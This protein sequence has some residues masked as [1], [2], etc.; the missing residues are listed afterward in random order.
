M[1][2]TEEWLKETLAKNPYLKVQVQGGKGEKA[3]QS[4]ENEERKQK[5][6]NHKIYEYEDG[7]VSDEKIISG[8]GAVA[9]IYDSTKEYCR[10]LDLQLMEKVGTITD[11]E[12]QK[13]L[14]IQDAFVYEK[15]H[16]QKIV[17]KADFCYKDADGKTIVCCSL[18][19]KKM[20]GCRQWHLLPM[21]SKLLKR[22]WS[23]AAPVRFLALSKAVKMSTWK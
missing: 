17:Y 4:K 9:A 11:L 21:V 7:F 18:K 23:F 12:R 5:Y 13:D 8:H 6:G 22:I 20:N 10:W 19:T 14:V 16:V 15:K 1:Q 2:L 3:K